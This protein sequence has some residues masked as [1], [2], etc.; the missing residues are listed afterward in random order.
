L[1]VPRWGVHHGIK[2][3]PRR[4]ILKVCPICNE[5]FLKNT[6]GRREY[7]KELCSVK[8]RKLKMREVNQRII[9]KRDKLKHADYMREL[10]SSGSSNKRIFSIGTD[11]IPKAELNDNGSVDWDSYHQ[12]LHNKLHRLGLT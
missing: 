2:F 8:A 10:Y 1:T 3:S 5:F 7:C 11:N 6:K 4:S 12:L 9:Q